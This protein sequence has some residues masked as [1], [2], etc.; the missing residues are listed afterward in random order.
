MERYGSL[1]LNWESVFHVEHSKELGPVEKPA[2]ITYLED[3]PQI[4]VRK[5]TA[6]AVPKT[7]QSACGFSR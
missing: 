7:M 3:R 4:S 5:G 1:E 6:L 2:D